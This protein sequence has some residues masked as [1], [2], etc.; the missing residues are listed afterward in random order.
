MNN[1]VQ[2]HLH[3]KFKNYSNVKKKNLEYKYQNIIPWKKR[4]KRLLL[5]SCFWILIFFWGGG[6]GVTKKQKIQFYSFSVKKKTLM[7]KITKKK[8]SIKLNIWQHPPKSVLIRGR[9]GLGGESRTS[10]RKV[11][12]GKKVWQINP[13]VPDG[14][15]DDH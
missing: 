13:F 14:L 7:N 15:I 3:F 2:I 11:R 1:A 9:R 6:W 12:L 8:S 10:S 5:S 4:G